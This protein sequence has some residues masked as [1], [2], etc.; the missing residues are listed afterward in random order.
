MTRGAKCLSV[1]VVSLFVAVCGEVSPVAFR[2][3]LDP[4]D[5]APVQARAAPEVSLP[6]L[7][8]P[9]GFSAVAGRSK[10][11]LRWNRI[12]GNSSGMV[13]RYIVSYGPDKDNPARQLEVAQT[14]APERPTATIPAYR[15]T[16]YVYVQV[17]T[18]G[19][20][21]EA[22]KCTGPLSGPHEIVKPASNPVPSAP[23]SFVAS[24]GDSREVTLRWGAANLH[25]LPFERYQMRR[26]FLRT[27]GATEETIA[28]PARKC[29]SGKGCTTPGE[30]GLPDGGV[31]RE[32]VDIV[33]WPDTTYLYTI[34]ARSEAGWGA[35]RSVKITA[36]PEPARPTGDNLAYDTT[37]VACD[38]TR[39]SSTCPPP[40]R[41]TV[42]SVRTHTTRATAEVEI[43]WVLP[44]TSGG[45]YRSADNTLRPA[46]FGYTG[47]NDRDATCTVRQRGPSNTWSA[48]PACDGTGTRLDAAFSDAITTYE[49]TF[50]ARANSDNCG[51]FKTGCPARDTV[52]WQG[53]RAT[54]TVTVNRPDTTTVTP[55]TTTALLPPSSVSATLTGDSLIITW[56]AGSGAGLQ[57][58]MVH[59][60]IDGETY[61][62]GGTDLDDRRMARWAILYQ[63]TFDVRV[64]FGVSSVKTGDVE[65]DIRWSNT[66]TIPGTTDN[67]PVT[68]VTAVAG[69]VSDAT[70]ATGE[71]HVAWHA[72]VVVVW[73]KKDG[74]GWTYDVYIVGESESYEV[75]G[76]RPLFIDFPE[77][78]ASQQLYVEARLPN[79]PLGRTQ[80][81]RSATVTV[82]TCDAN[83]VEPPGPPGPR[84]GGLPD[85]SI[86]IPHCDAS[87]R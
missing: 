13:T 79:E 19:T 2:D 53:A 15:E 4:P 28:H 9:T 25:N 80:Y 47:R 72:G 21:G 64:R 3:R 8:R 42:G 56:P 41:M 73:T 30:L 59:E 18:N 62:V 77:D 1:F 76:W 85:R 58:Y 36:K 24:E 20:C 6:T 83:A 17:G 52:F 34:R 54:R 26:Y 84:G 55:P 63:E 40:G 43:N 12:S 70:T 61:R 32:Y 45:R 49:V 69:W 48:G 67:T 86:W 27:D 35:T 74:P 39:V 71:G 65:S 10:H 87:N 22:G 82:T 78:G 57:G 33:P 75:T 81:R 7:P 46:A 29:V 50:T 23:S 5:D 38:P 16:L 11:W 68:D 31:A 60:D 66:V 37:F 51:R 44:A 14:D